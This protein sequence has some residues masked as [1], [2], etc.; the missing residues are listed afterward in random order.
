MFV[1][2]VVS[3][4]QTG[5]DRAALDVALALGVKCGGWVPKGRLDEDG[6]IPE[7]YPDLKETDSADPKRR[8][9]LNVL[10]SDATL[11]FSHGDL[12][13]GSL[14]TREVAARAGKPVKHVDLSRVNIE[15][16]AA[17]IR[18][19]LSQ[20]QPRVLNIAGPRASEDQNI[21]AATKAVLEH[22]LSG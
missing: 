10:D 2:R 1:E 11:I 19:W 18:A 17:G 20:I 8:T 3:G 4:G 12:T 9:E 6:I 5:A 7:R 21:Y 15:T 16:A 22:V 14:H 13:G